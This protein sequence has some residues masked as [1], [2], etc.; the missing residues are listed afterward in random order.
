VNTKKSL[1]YYITPHGFGHAIRSCEIMRVLT[2]IAPDLDITVVS[3]LPEW[4]LEHNI[5]RRLPMRPVFLDLG[6]SQVDSLHSD[7]QK[8]LSALRDLMNKAEAIV[9]AEV[10]FLR[11]ENVGLVVSDV[12]FLPL[13]AAYRCGI[14]S[15]GISNFT[16][17]WIYSGYEINDAG[18]REIVSWTRESY[19]KCSLFLQLPMHGDCSACPAVEDIPL[20]ARKASRNG[21]EVRRALGIDPDRKVF[22]VSFT[23][24][25][26]EPSAAKRLEAMEGVLFLCGMPLELPLSNAR[27]FDAAALP[28]VDVVAA[29]DGVIT[30]PG[31]GIVSDCLANGTPM[32]YTGRGP[33]REYPFLVEEIEKSLSAVYLPAREFAEGAWEGA[34]RE[35]CALPRKTSPMRMDGAE[36]AARRILQVLHGDGSERAEDI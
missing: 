17:D 4:L 19:R 31:Y 9:Q 35:I 5:G 10:E 24:L 6:L 28:Y 30:K 26:L 29:V 15:I 34:I 25:R 20:V 11:R 2:R 33:F 16:W 18:W 14:T 1:A 23:A 13:D 21:G 22:L 12:A 36:V 27:G 8:S 32:I 7:L 3:V